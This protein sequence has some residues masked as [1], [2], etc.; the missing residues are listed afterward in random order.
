MRKAYADMS[1]PE[2]EAERA[3]QLEKYEAF[4]RRGLKLNMARGVPGKDQIDLAQ[5]MLTLL[6][7]PEDYFADG[8]DTRTYNAPLADGLPCAKKLFA[9]LLEVPAEQVIVGGNS[10]LSMMFDAVARGM[11]FGF[12]GCEPWARQGKIK[13]LCPVPGYD[14]HFSVC[15][16]FGIEMLPVAMDEN[17]PD[18]A[19]V[20]ELVKDP[21]V[22]GMWC[23]PKYSN[24][25]GVTYSDETVRALA[26]LRPAA[27]DFRVFYDNA[28]CAHGWY[29]DDKLLNIFDAL[30]ERNLVFMFA[31]TAKISFPGA[32]VACMA[33]GKE[34]VAQAKKIISMQ[35]IGP[36]KANQL[37]HVKYFRNA[38][39]IR[40]HMQKHAALVRPKCDAVLGEL[41]NELAYTGIATWTRPRGGYFISLDAYEG[42]AKEI[43][44]LAEKG[45]VLL[46]TP[47]GSTWPYKKD[48]KDNSIRIAPT[49]PSAA[50][51]KQAA[52]LLCICVKLAALE[53][54]LAG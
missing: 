16:S 51:I 35:T 21:A 13:W 40:A 1:R 11:C 42:T 24:P 43:I 3:G 7:T 25:S 18:M 9:E 39:G 14:R 28:Y 5:D 17:G 54:L 19:A 41:D 4:K 32:G 53:K 10:S 29:G 26:A 38:D 48:P 44:A 2:L 46:T 31:S 45:G 50:D 12:G 8:V 37:R 47:A 33:A 6:K 30:G 23:V 34:D 20:A 15:E 36:D 52:E 22:K 27:V 49:F